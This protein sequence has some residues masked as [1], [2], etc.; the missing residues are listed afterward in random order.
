M[1]MSRSLMTSNISFLQIWKNLDKRAT[2]I[3]RGIL[4]SSNISFTARDAV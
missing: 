3:V 1:I 4:A 2:G